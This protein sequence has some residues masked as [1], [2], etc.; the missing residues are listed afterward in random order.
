MKR[1]SISVPTPA[2]GVAEEAVEEAPYRT[3]VPL[4]PNPAVE[5]AVVKDASAL[6]TPIAATT[7]GMTFAS[8][9][10][11]T[12]AADVAEA[13][14]AEELKAVALEVRMAVHRVMGPDVVDANAN[15]ASAV[16]TRIAA[17]RP[18]MRPA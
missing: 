15:P 10:A 16:L 17:I 6:P 3:V 11:P 9:S 7:H 13:D 12:T 8:G 2:G 14:L 18:G 5:D 4:R 1:V